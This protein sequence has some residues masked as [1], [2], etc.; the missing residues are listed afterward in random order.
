[1]T[2]PT[3]DLKPK[4]PRGRP[5]KAAKDSVVESSEAPETTAESAP[6]ISHRA[7]STR[8]H[9]APTATRENA[10][11]SSLPEIPDDAPTEAVRA[12]STAADPAFAVPADK[13][14]VIGIL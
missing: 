3:D 5:P 8:S 4:R 6:P 10:R 14:V 11:E 13:R 2:T 1:M 12:G 9:R 7:P